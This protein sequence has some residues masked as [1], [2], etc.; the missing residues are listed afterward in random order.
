MDP[1]EIRPECCSGFRITRS[2]VMVSG[3]AKDHELLRRRNRM[4]R[5]N[6]ETSLASSIWVAFERLC[7]LSSLQRLVN[8]CLDPQL[9]LC[10]TDIVE[11]TYAAV[12]IFTYSDVA[13]QYSP[14]GYK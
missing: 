9:S 12:T 6:M 1:F 3:A 5:S 7:D 2:R 11:K 14:M 8:L 4:L 13:M 10:S